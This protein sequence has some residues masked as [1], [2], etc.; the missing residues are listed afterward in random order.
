LK[1]HGNIP[2]PTHC[3]YNPDIISSSISAGLSIIDPKMR[4]VWHNK[5]Y[6]KWFGKISDLR[7][8]HCY[9]IYEKRKKIC[10]GC[11]TLKVFKH[12]YDKC[13]SI[14]RGIVTKLGGKRCFKLTTS[15]IKDKKGNVVQVIELV[16]DITDH[17]KADRLVKK[18]LSVVTKELHFISRLDKRFVSLKDI[19][20]EK[21]LGECAEIVRLLIGARVANIRLLEGINKISVEKDVSGL[22]RGSL[23]DMIHKFGCMIS[24]KAIRSRRPFFMA[25]LKNCSYYNKFREYI[26]TCGI[27]STI[28]VPIILKKEAI[29]TIAVYDRNTNIIKEDAYRLLLYFSNHVAILI[30]DIRAHREIFTSYLDTI[31]SLVTAIEAKDIYNK[32]HSEKVTKLSLDIAYAMG[33]DK[34]ETALL[35]YSGR[36]HDIGK[37]AI[38]DLILNKKGPLNEEERAEIQLHP[39]KGA[40]ILAHLKFLDKCIPI[41]R[42][43]HERYDGKGYPDGLKGNHIPFLARI[44]GCADAFDAMTSD[45]AY[46]PRLKLEDAIDELHKNRGGQFDPEVTDIFTKLITSKEEQFTYS[47]PTNGLIHSGHKI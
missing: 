29:G 10:H 8:R 24:D 16:E 4:I 39:I 9:E 40:Q 28:C 47:I 23:W 36:L 12:G 15:P 38:P 32:G 37:L 35:N 18:K 41:I 27:N 33:L 30:D 31:E 34:E 44:I 19:S 3:S 13:T 1:K 43:H 17:I 20:L 25:E 7:G 2:V 45:R 6:E 26:N 21:V 22:D 46:R 5:L 42:H 11:P 14:R